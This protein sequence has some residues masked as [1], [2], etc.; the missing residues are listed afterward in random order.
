MTRVERDVRVTAKFAHVIALAMLSVV[1]AVVL[2]GCKNAI[3]NLSSDGTNH[4]ASNAVVN[5]KYA[6]ASASGIVSASNGAQTY[7]IKFVLGKTGTS[8][9]VTGAGWPGK[10]RVSSSGVANEQ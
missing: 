8:N 10:I 3:P 5:S 9:S 6:L 1:L 7:K 2:A 4:P